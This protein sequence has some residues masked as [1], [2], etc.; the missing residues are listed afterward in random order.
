MIHLLTTS[1]H[2]V[3]LLSFHTSVTGVVLANASLDIALHDTLLTTTLIGVPGKISQ[4]ILKRFLVGLIDGDGSIQVNHWRGKSLQFRI[5]VKLALNV[6]NVEM[7]NFIVSQFS[8][9]V[10]I[11]NGNNPHKKQEVLW[12][13]DS[14][15]IIVSVLLP[16]FDL[17]PPLTTRITLQLRFLRLALAGLSMEEYFQLRSSKYD[18]R[19]TITPLIIPNSLPVYFPGWLAGFIE[20]GGCFSLRTSGVSTFS[21]SLQHDRYLMEAIKCYFE[22]HTNNVRESSL[23]QYTLEVA[24]RAGVRRVLDF[25]LQYPLQGHKYY[26]LLDYFHKTSFCRLSSLH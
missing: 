8:G 13:V 5:A 15:A 24:S 12:V 21:L 4:D 2:S 7:L 14:K 25:S 6:G 17:Y 22:L 26:Q 18:L 1:R 9:R 10:R 23:Q 19:S 3:I 16:I 20:A 11:I